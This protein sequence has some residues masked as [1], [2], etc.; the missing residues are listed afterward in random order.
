MKN[1]F[2]KF[3]IASKLKK[4]G[5]NEP[6]FGH[7]ENQNK[8]LVINYTNLPPVHPM[9]KK[10]PTMFEV[11]NIN[12]NLPQW[13]TSAPTYQQVADWLRENH[14]IWIELPYYWIEGKNVYRP[15]LVFGI[16]HKTHGIYNDY[17]K[18]FDKAIVESLKLIDKI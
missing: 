14:N 18:A 3:S 16:E 8:K 10:R 15:E 1:L 13:A 11:N 6:C 2:V 4:K 9:A 17:Y 5:F 12:S 7:Y